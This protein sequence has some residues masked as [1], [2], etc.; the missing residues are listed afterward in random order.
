MRLL[1]DR[2]KPHRLDY[3][4]IASANIFL[5]VI[6]FDPGFHAEGASI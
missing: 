3:A 6:E 5:I 4:L 2:E 1:A